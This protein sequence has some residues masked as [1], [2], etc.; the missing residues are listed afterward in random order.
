ML[1]QLWD[2]I[3]H[4]G[5]IA[6]DSAIEKRR[7]ILLNRIYI[8][9]IACGGLF[10]FTELIESFTHPEAFRYFTLTLVLSLISIAILTLY[11]NRYRFF[12][13]PKFL[14]FF[15][16]PT[17][18]TLLPIF[19]GILDDY[20][21]FWIQFTPL[22]FSTVMHIIIDRHKEKPLYVLILVYNLFLLFSFELFLSLNPSP[23]IA[24]FTAIM[25]KDYWSYK[26][27]QLI[28]WIMVN[29]AFFYQIQL[30]EKYEKDLSTNNVALQNSSLTIQQKNEEIMQQNEEIM[31][32]YEEIM[33]QREFVNEKNKVLEA[34]NRQINH[35]LN[36]ALLI[37]QAILPYTEK[38]NKLLNEYFILYRP[39][40]VVSGDFYWLNTQAN[41]TIVVAADCTGHGVS[42]AFMTL[43]GNTL[44]DKIV[45]VWN[46]TSPAEILTK[47]HEEI[48]IV[49]KQDYNKNNNGMD[50]TILNVQ[51][52]HI[53]AQSY[54]L[55]FAGA[56]TDL[57]YADAR[58]E[59]M[60]IEKIKGTRKAI[61]GAQNE[62]LQFENHTLHLARRSCVYIGSDGLADQNDIKRKKFGE[63]KLI[64]ILNTNLQK[65][66]HI[67]KEIL[68]Q[69][70]E[71]HMED[72]PQRDDI[73]WIGFR[74]P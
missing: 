20:D 33:M 34:K 36:A 65:E 10:L 72:V 64:E 52:S 18:M 68:I 22:I 11:L 57:Y 3:S 58:K 51:I 73:L 26:I 67:Q 21:I 49:L 41:A 43:I 48:R 45:R 25:F 42:G 37:Q 59:P 69:S 56:K 47:L 2:T 60:K 53:E 32:G 14:F 71:Q 66:M 6:S 28:I 9:I 24:P 62:A 30:A 23:T 29:I 12:I 74:L 35:S 38:L 61:G 27:G 63:N 55:Q 50:I 13:L 4:I 70:L 17:S 1:K 31:Q 5:I 46:I 40:D 16:F 7:I 19:M 15:L 54:Q 8:A 39:K 44:L